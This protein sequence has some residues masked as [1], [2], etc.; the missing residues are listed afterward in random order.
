MEQRRYKVL[1]A[2]DEYWSRENIKNLIPW[3]TYSMDLLK[4]AEDGEEVQE[5]IPTERPDILLTDINMP[6]LNGLELLKWISEHYPDII[7]IAVSG[8]DD[9][10]KVKGVFTSGGIDYLLKP[11]GREQLVDVLSKAIEI[12]EEREKQANRHHRISSFIEDNEFSNIL[13]GKLYATRS[14]ATATRQDTANYVPT[15]F[16]KFHNITGLSQRY[17]YDMPA[18]SVAIKKVLRELMEEEDALIFNYCSKVNEFLICLSADMQELKSF[19]ERVIER[20]PVEEGPITVVVRNRATVLDDAAQVY[21]EMVATMMTRPFVR[22]HVLLECIRQENK[23]PVSGEIFNQSLERNLISLLR[24]QEEDKILS[25]IFEKGRLQYCEADGWSILDMTQYLARLTGILLSSESVPAHFNELREEIDETIR[26]AQMS[27]DKETIWDNIRLAVH[28][29]C[30]E[31]EK[32]HDGSVSKQ[33]EKIHEEI[34]NRFYEHF[35]LSGLG[36]KYHVEPSYLSRM[37]SQ[38]YGESITAYT[39]RLRIE[40][41]VE[42]MREDDRNLEAI[43]FE[44][45]YDDYNYFSR[46]FKKQMGL[47]P[48]EYRKTKLANGES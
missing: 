27:V 46:V 9:Y 35:D 12:I 28:V 26:F 38:Q 14:V 10:Q 6:F 4:P 48:S 7:T 34:T 36:E 5:R 1:I 17:E 15:V 11:V 42:L 37:F 24:S 31:K 43:S 29:F 40:K 18:M 22:Q 45:G 39:T 44:V 47:R 20:F 2:D 19:G 25:C 16:V 33:I 3:E 13:N 23:N 41:A 30:S 21:R 8:Y 32:P